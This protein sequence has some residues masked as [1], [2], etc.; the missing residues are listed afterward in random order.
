MGR[1]RVP[2]ARFGKVLSP[3]APALRRWSD[4]V[5]SKVGRDT[6][7]ACKSKIHI[8]TLTMI[9]VGLGLSMNSWRVDQARTS[10][11]PRHAIMKAGSGQLA[12]VRSRSIP[13]QNAKP[14]KMRCG[15]ND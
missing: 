14:W 11:N 4:K 1:G 7:T 10:L 8:P 6:T 12:A 5:Q 15:E 2:K 3:G 9:R 13:P